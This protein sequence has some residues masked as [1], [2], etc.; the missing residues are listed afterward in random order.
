MNIQETMTDEQ[1]IRYRKNILLQE[2]GTDGQQ[3]LM[4]ARVLIMGTGGL[5]SPVSLY[6][7]AAGIGHIGIV[8]AD[9]VDVSNLQ[10]QVIHFTKD[11]GRLKVESAKEK[12]L[13]MNPN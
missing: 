11:V 7:A 9:A 10:R 6:L 5:G 13:A 4:D 2:V 3:K 12:I 8:D 1:L